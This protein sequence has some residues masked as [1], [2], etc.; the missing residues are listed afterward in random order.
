MANKIYDEQENEAYANEVGKKG[1]V[2]A[3]VGLATVA[4]GAGAF[5][6][7]TTTKMSGASKWATT[8]TIPRMAL[9]TA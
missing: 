2:N 1:L 3:G 9:L 5:F 6:A 7:A 4:A 8:I